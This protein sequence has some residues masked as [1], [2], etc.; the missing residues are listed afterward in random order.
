MVKAG[1]IVFA[2]NHG[3][4]TEIIRHPD[5]L[6]ANV[7]DAVTKICVVLSSPDKQDSLRAHL[8]HCAERFGGDIFMKESLAAVTSSATLQPWA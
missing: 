3:G 5:L 6:F 4:P 7:D 1:A 8:A 2:P